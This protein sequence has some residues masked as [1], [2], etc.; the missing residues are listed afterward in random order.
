MNRQEYLNKSKK[1]KCGPGGIKCSCC[2]PKV[3]KK[4]IHKAIRRKMHQEK[5]DQ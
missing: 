4:N 1:S 3:G 2:Q 5:L